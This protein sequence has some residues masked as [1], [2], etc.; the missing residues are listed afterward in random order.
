MM[1]P[2][3]RSVL[4]GTASDALGAPSKGVV[5]LIRAGVRKQSLLALLP[6]A[7]LLLSLLYTLLPVPQRGSTYTLASQASHAYREAIKSRGKILVSYSYFEKD[8][9]QV[10]CGC[11]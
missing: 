1:S 6:W 10:S 8:Q 9:I 5:K 4:M 11:E 7:L 3:N 2:G